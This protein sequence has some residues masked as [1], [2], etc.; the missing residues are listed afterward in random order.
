MYDETNSTIKTVEVLVD[1]A[2][3]DSVNYA[4]EFILNGM[5][6]TTQVNKSLFENLED[7]LA[8]IKRPV[9]IKPNYH[10]VEE[11]KG[12]DTYYFVTDDCSYANLP[13]MFAL[14]DVKDNLYIVQD[15]SHGEAGHPAYYLLVNSNGNSM[16]KYVA[17]FP[18]T[19]K[20]G[21]FIL[22]TTTF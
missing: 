7:C 20:K 18:T 5:I 6:V 4:D 8:A 13:I 9:Y 2:N 14:E 3:E 10:V 22:Y 12:T 17:N 16:V 15:I 21:D 1:K 11:K 19:F